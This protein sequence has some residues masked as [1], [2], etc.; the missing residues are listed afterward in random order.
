[1]LGGEVAVS[2]HSDKSFDSADTCADGPFGEERNHTK[3]TG[4]LSVRSAAQLVRPVPYRHH[5]N[6]RTVLLAEQRHRTHRP[7]LV[8]R[9][10]LGVNIEVLD[11]DLIDPGLYIAQHR[12]GDRL[13]T[14]E[15]EP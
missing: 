9:H 5:S 13:R 12:T 6:F 11:Q 10:D 3:L 8:L 1:M 15:V 14:R 2:I 4:S 7:R